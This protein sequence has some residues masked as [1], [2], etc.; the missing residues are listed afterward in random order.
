MQIIVKDK[1]RLFI[2]LCLFL[3]IGIFVGR[4]LTYKVKE[5]SCQKGDSAQIKQC[6]ED[7][8]Q[9]SMK[10]GDLGGAFDAL[11]SLYDANPALG[12][13]CHALT[14]KIG[15]S[16][17]LLFA[18][19]KTFAVTP[20]TAYCSYG[21]YHGFME[22]LVAEKKDMSLARKFCD[23]VDEEIS[24]VSPDASL[25]CLHGIGHGTVNNHDPRTWGSEQTLIDPAI[26]LCK[27]VATN[28]DELSRCAT[29][30]FNGIAN[31]YATGEYKLVLNAS[32]PLK[33]CRAQAKQF[34]DPCYISLNT[35]LLQLTEYDLKKAVVFIDGIADDT[36][37]QH[38]M[39]NVAAPIGSANLGKLDHAGVIATC[40]SISK[41]LHMSC[42]QGYAYGFLEHGEP[43]QEYKKSLEFCQSKE[44]V[45]DEQN[46]CFEYIFSYLP[47]WYSRDKVQAICE[48]LSGEYRTLCEQKVNKST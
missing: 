7:V 5:P 36:M 34:Q 46:A 13:T 47:M 43:E 39:I 25:Q 2:V 3:G 4:A 41:R 8:V 15:E 22:A 27:Q 11:A 42:I 21:F 30:V 31:F 10:Q 40:R 35:L 23:Y 33:V 38:T 44:L 1:K 29:G 19:G 26:A 48:K 17:Y 12:E 18:R 9:S 6:W 24:A 14:H 16:A 45:L 28:D 32:D 37:A 20:K